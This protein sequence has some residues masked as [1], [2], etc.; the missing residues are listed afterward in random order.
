MRKYA[1]QAN[2]GVVYTSC[3]RCRGN[4]Y[5]QQSRHE[6]QTDT[7]PSHVQG[8]F[9]PR[10]RTP[11]V[12]LFAAILVS[13]AGFTANTSAMA[14]WRPPVGPR[15]TSTIASHYICAR[16]ASAAPPRSVGRHFS[17]T[18]SG[19]AVTRAPSSSSLLWL[20]RRLKVGIPACGFGTRLAEETDKIPK[21]MVPVGNRPILWHIMMNS[22]AC[23]LSDFAIALR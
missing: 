15:K 8:S 18:A 22:Y 11:R 9:L 5:R 12:I 1:K 19:S 16:D 20:I 4:R 2:R 6:Q 23:G 13:P 3:R 17:L 10:R 7:C 14:G 21:P